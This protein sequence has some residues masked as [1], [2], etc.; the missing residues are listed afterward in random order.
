MPT[1]DTTARRSFRAKCNVKAEAAQIVPRPRPE[2]RAIY[3]QTRRAAQ[4][5]QR[6]A[7]THRALALLLH[8]Q[9]EERMCRGGSV[10]LAVTL[11]TQPPT[12]LLHLGG[13]R[14]CPEDAKARLTRNSCEQ[15]QTGCTI[16]PTGVPYSYY[17]LTTMQNGLGRTHAWLLKSTVCCMERGALAV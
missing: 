3:S 2:G 12:R 10:S 9:R 5:V 17:K 16:V 14:V 1:S 7:W 13:T 8:Q 15:L 6:R 4:P 11:F